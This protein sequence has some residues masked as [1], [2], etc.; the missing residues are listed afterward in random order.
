M[1]LSVAALVAIYILWSMSFRPG[2]VEWHVGSEDSES[3]AM[4]R[5]RDGRLVL[6]LYMPYRR[7]YYFRAPRNSLGSVNQLLDDDETYI[8]ADFAGWGIAGPHWAFALAMVV[9]PAW[10]WM[11]R[12]QRAQTL[13]RRTGGLCRNCGYDIRASDQ[14]C[15]ECGEPVPALALRD[16]H[17]PAHDPANDPKTN[18]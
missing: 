10:W 8:A 11:A 4:L 7:S 1:G 9:I 15:P 12:H 16:L 13:H 6:G 17:Q 18:A 3:R 5:S 14:R 2:G